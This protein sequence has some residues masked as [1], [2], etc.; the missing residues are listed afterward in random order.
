[1]L[2]ADGATRRMQS[3]LKQLWV[4]LGRRLEACHTFAYD[5]R[6]MPHAAETDGAF[7]SCRQ[8]VVQLRAVSYAGGTVLI[9]A[10]RRAWRGGCRGI[11]VAG[12]RVRHPVADLPRR[13]LDTRARPELIVGAQGWA[14]DGR[15]F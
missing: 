2:D 7:S 13:G 14:R 15:M 10:A 1:V 3:L 4:V 9:R 5:V 8:Q 6:Q 11:W 12:L